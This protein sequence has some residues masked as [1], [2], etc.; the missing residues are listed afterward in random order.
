MQTAFSR[1]GR[2]LAALVPVF[3]AS[4]AFAGEA[5]IRLPDVKGAQF[6]Y[7]LTGNMLMMIGLGISV[8]GALFGW[9]Q[10]KQTVA[11]PAHKSMLSV[12]NIIW[13]TCKSYI[14]QQGKYLSVL[15]LLIAVAIV[16]YFGILSPIGQ[17]VPAGETPINKW[18][19]V[20]VVLLASILGI[21]GSYG[22]AW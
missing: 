7:G 6:A 15:W 16:G 17:D 22:V 21:L 2:A 5:D 4:A 1:T 14:I 8:L 3:V 20:V 11:L 18:F 13:E 9:V 19:A 12:S 10:Y